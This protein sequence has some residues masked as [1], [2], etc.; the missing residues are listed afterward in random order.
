[1]WYTITKNR[2]HDGDTL[3]VKI[4]FCIFK[5][6]RERARLEE[7]KKA[8]NL[9]AAEERVRRL[10]LDDEE[11]KVIDSS[12]DNH[13]GVCVPC[14]LMEYRSCS[15]GLNLTFAISLRCVLALKIT[16]CFIFQW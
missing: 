13:K 10:K 16:S 15:H 9:K 3:M 7:Q 12:M 14:N 11:R 4:C 1:M 6:A 5:D 8:D 2:D